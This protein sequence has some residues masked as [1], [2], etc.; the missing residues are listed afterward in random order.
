MVKIV[1][2]KR[3]QSK[4]ENKENN[5]GIVQSRSVTAVKPFNR[6][7]SCSSN[8]GLRLS[9][10]KVK[11]D[12]SFISDMGE[13]E[14]GECKEA[15]DKNGEITQSLDSITDVNSSEI[16]QNLDIISDVNTSLREIHNNSSHSKHRKVNVSEKIIAQG[17]SKSKMIIR[18]AEKTSEG[19]QLSVPVLAGLPNSQQRKEYSDFS[20]TVNKPEADQSFS[21]STEFIIVDAFNDNPAILGIIETPELEEDP[22]DYVSLATENYCSSIFPFQCGVKS[23]QKACTSKT[24]MDTHITKFHASSIVV[25]DFRFNLEKAYL[26]KRRS[27]LRTPCKALPEL[28]L[29]HALRFK[30]MLNMEELEKEYKKYVRF[31]N[32][33]YYCVICQNLYCNQLLVLRHLLGSKHKQIANR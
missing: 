2:V 5:V 11:A 26:Y 10:L 19:Y 3:R 12:L 32:E 24:D 8:D 21:K 23:C 30:T 28:D 18:T 9:G 6:T 1:K 25:T 22:L 15:T 27:T 7:K 17:L 20:V 4:A 31:K 14:A 29:R 13:S 33:K 16:T